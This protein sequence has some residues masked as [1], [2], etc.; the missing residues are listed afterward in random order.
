M[1]DINKTIN[2]RFLTFRVVEPL[3][4]KK[5]STIYVD[6]KDGDR[7]G[8]IYYHAPWRRNVFAPNRDTIFD[9]KCL[10]DIDKA[11][12]FAERLRTHGQTS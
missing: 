5:T 8:K 11:I 1:P 7:L 4:A 12:D 10:G 9:K 3:G 6:N 2:S